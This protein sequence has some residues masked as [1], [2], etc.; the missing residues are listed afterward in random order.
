MTVFIALVLT[1]LVFAFIAY[2]LLKQRSPSVDSKEDEKSRE[3]HSKRDTTDS[4]LKELE[5]DFQSGILTEED[6]RDLEAEYKSKAVSILKK[7]DDVGKDANLEEEIEK[8]VLGLRQDRGRFCPQCGVKCQEDDR[9]CS[10]CGTTL[11]LGESV[12]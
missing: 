10:R 1:V 5:Y 7:L 4:M 2:P 12:D 8:Q 9:F 6:Y 11:N 3:L